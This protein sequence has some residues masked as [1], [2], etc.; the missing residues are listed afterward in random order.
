MSHADAMQDEVDDEA[1]RRERSTIAFPYGDLEAA[2]EVARAIYSRAGFGD[3][4]FDEIAAE[5]GQT[6]SG[7][8]RAKAA[9][10]R[11]FGVVDK[12][13]RSAFKLSD[14]GR[15]LFDPETEAEARVSAFLAVPLYNEI[16]A[17]YRGRTLP[18]PRALEKEMERLG[19]SP[20]QTDKARQ[21]FERSARQAGFFDSGDDR[22][23]KPRLERTE[24]GGQQTSS[25][26][27]MPPA[28]TVPAP[29]PQPAAARK[30][31]E[32]ELVDLLKRPNLKEEHRQAIWILVQFLSEKDGAQNSPAPDTQSSVATGLPSPAG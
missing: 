19:V 9:T 32:Y 12:T 16:F 21:A 1:G 20:K 5:L 6:V 14:L 28:H 13:A 24:K 3:C 30:P 4:D 15:R 18:S 27:G 10:A 8:F 26:E 25:D 22:L 11:T 31:L 17:I 2:I 7:A 29:A 23:V